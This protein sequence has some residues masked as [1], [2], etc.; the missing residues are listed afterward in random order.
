RPAHRG[1]PCPPPRW[2]THPRGPAWGR[3]TGGRDVGDPRR[4]ERRQCRGRGGLNL[5]RTGRGAPSG[6]GCTP[7]RVSTV[8]WS[9]CGPSHQEGRPPRGRAVDRSVPSPGVQAQ[10]EPDH[11]SAAFPVTGQDL[12]PVGVGDLPHHG[13]AKTRSGQT[14]RAG[15]TVEAFE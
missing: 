2:G 8:P 13:Q 15:G 7:S 10:T 9:S 6:G 5:L 3:G 12:S 14:T 11:G 4:A 1:D